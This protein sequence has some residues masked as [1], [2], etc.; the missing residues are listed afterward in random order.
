MKKLIIGCLCSIFIIY[1]CNNSVENSI[2]K[3]SNT[4]S[5]GFILKGTLKSYLA[6]KV[7]L[8]KIIEN[9][10]YPIDSAIIENN[11]FFFKGMV[12]YPERFALTF[13][14]Y[15]AST[16]LIVENTSFEIEINPTLI[17]NPIIKGSPLNATLTEYKLASKK[18]FSKIELLFPKFQKARLENDADK[19][20]E[21]GNEMK[22][23]ETEFRDYSY[24]FIKKNK[25]S[26]VAGMILRDQLKATSI[27]TIRIRETYKLLSKKV[28]KGT[29]AQL[30]EISL[31]ISNDH[32]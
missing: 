11:R 27:D 28:K 17:E 13:E 26:Y 31:S 29:D 8:N 19:L 16:I 6:N 10:I 12:T 9:T 1:S 21:I 4:T 3:E 5:N 23:I 20:T 2:K 32:N 7:Y 24:D 25:D 14:N 15:S 18:I 22:T 30:I